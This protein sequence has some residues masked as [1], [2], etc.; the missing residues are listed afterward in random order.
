MSVLREKI[1][2][3]AGVTET[4]EAFRGEIDALKSEN[5]QLR[6]LNRERDRELADQRDKYE[7]M[8]SRVD[9]L[10]KERTMLIN[11]VRLLI[12]I[13]FKLY[14]LEFLKYK[15]VASTEVGE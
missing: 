8:G 3:Q 11:N 1:T 2:G 15:N 14:W 6:Q 7:Q 10:E 9:S 5:A 12:A 4:Y 13:K